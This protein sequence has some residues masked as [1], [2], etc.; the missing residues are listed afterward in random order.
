MDTIK[1]KLE[2]DMF[3]PNLMLLC[4]INYEKKRQN[5]TGWM[6]F[7]LSLVS[8]FSY[9]YQCQTTLTGTKTTT[10]KT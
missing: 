2:N 7:F 9:Y 6:L 3:L 8:L 5:N 10:T 1:I 4:Y